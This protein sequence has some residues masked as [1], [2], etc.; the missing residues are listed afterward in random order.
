[1]RITGHKTAWG[2]RFRLPLMFV[3][4]VLAGASLAAQEPPPPAWFVTIA[5]LAA[6]L[7]QNDSVGAM[8]AF[9][10]GAKDYATIESS[11]EA[12]VSQTEILCAIDPVQDK[13]QGKEQGKEEDK[14]S[15]GFHDLDV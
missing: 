12:L 8:Q 13:E 7:S 6:S 2:G 5:H 3:A 14:E 11:I 1:M 15:G 9:D 4:S 10:R